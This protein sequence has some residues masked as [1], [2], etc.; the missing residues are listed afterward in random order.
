MYFVGY[1][2]TEYWRY[3]CENQLRSDDENAWRTSLIEATPAEVNESGMK[4]VG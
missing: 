1:G 4:Y 3:A 2:D